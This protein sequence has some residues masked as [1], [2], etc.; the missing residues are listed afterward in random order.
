MSK[1]HL[2]LGIVLTITFF[3]V[4]GVMVSPIWDGKN[5]MEYADGLFNTFSKG[6][7]YFIP[8]VSEKA[9]KYVGKELKVTIK[10]KDSSEAE[11]T[12]LLYSKAGVDVDVSG[13]VITISGDL[14]K[15]LKSALADADAMYK[16]EGKT[17]YEKYG[18]NEKEA[19]YYWWVSLKKIANDYKKSSNKDKINAGI[20]IEKEIITRAIEPAY[21]YY[22]IEAKNIGEGAIIAAGLLVFYVVYTLWWGFAIYNLFVGLGLR[23]EKAKEKKEV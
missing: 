6:S 16:N 9:E 4:L 11:K 19:M 17:L 2:M 14:G 5:F 18:Y 7:V 21:N 23:M 22:G 20:F 8:K 3:G 1:K 12:A 13:N 10:M 15:I